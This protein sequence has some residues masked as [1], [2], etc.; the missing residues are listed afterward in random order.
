MSLE[1]ETKIFDRAMV[2]E[3]ID[4]VSAQILEEPEALAT[5]L[6]TQAVFCNYS[7]FNTMLIAAQNPAATKLAGREAWERNGVTINQGAEPIIIQEPVFKDKK[8]YKER[9]KA[10]FK[11]KEAEKP[12]DYKIKEVYDVSQT[13]E[14]V[15]LN[16]I[17]SY[18]VLTKALFAIKVAPLKA[19]EKPLLAAYDETENAIL[20]NAQMKR[21]NRAFYN[22]L[23][24]AVA[25][26]LI[27]E[28]A[29]TVGNS[30]KNG[31]PNPKREYVREMWLAED[32]ARF[33]CECIAY[34]MDSRYLEEDGR[35]NKQIP[36]P[37]E[38]YR[39]ADKW[40]MRA[41]LSNMQK[42]YNEFTQKVEEV[43]KGIFIRAKPE[44]KAADGQEREI[45]IKAP[46][47]ENQ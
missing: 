36:Y 4:A 34:M 7:V 5:W 18:E 15:C 10:G 28:K 3:T 20:F 32:V 26:S 14:G 42:L 33:T 38:Q 23:T 17:K 47:V 12:V 11:Q 13:S 19:T 21:G 25:M 16:E 46:A 27:K 1:K 40:Q 41:V 29:P 6:N 45:K 31:K 35:Y 39:D 22:T 2:E 8:G 24:Y 37:P 30:G 9:G 43:A 44:A